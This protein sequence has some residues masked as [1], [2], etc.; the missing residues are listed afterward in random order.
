MAKE[1]KGE[2]RFDAIGFNYGSVKGKPGA[3]PKR[4]I[5]GM[6]LTIRPGDSRMFKAEWKQVDA[7]G[8]PV[9]AGLYRIRAWIVGSQ[10]KAERDLSIE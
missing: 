1:F 2:I 3:D 10:E 5:D 8:Q 6:T 7:G 9:P 4:V